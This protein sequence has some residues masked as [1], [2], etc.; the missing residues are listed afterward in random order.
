MP[1]ECK[2]VNKLREE[3]VAKVM[4]KEE[5]MS[6]ICRQYGISRTTGYKWVARYLDGETMQDKSHEPFNKPYKTNGDTEQM[7]LSVRYDRVMTTRLG[8]Q[9]KLRG[10]LKTKDNMTCLQSVQ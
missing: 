1:W 6:S 7:I 5:S 4:L 8:E 2:T 9:E 3:F 10:F